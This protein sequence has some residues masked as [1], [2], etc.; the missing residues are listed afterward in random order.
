MEL[1]KRLGDMRKQ[2]DQLTEK[3]TQKRTR[4]NNEIEEEKRDDVSSKIKDMETRLRHL[5]QEYNKIINIQNMDNEKSR[6]RIINNY[7]TNKGDHK[8]EGDNSK[9]NPKVFIKILKNK[10]R[11]LT[12]KDDIKEMIR[13]SLDS[14]ALIWFTGKED[15]IEDFESFEE[16]FIKYFWGN[17]AQTKSRE[18]LY[19]GKYDTRKGYNMNEYAM[20]IYSNAKFL[21]P[22]IQEE[23]IIMF[24][25]RHYKPEITETIAIQNIKSIEQLSNY[26]QRIERNRNCNNTNI[27][28]DNSGHQLNNRGNINN[29]SYN[30]IINNQN[31]RRNNNF[32]NSYNQNDINWNNNYSRNNNNYNFRNH[33]NNNSNNYS[34][35]NNQFNN[36][37]NNINNNNNN[38]YQ[39]NNRNGYTNYRNGNNTN[40]QQNNY[41]EERREQNQSKE[42]RTRAVNNTR[43]MQQENRVITMEPEIVTEEVPDQNFVSSTGQM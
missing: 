30:E 40:Y 41:R 14:H 27:R 33:G 12:N 19:F 7:M 6:T 23:E 10:I 38:R 20:K 35:Y 11:N 24:L 37:D 16:H 4:V 26:L 2:I 8:F 32:H 42:E 15:E 21:D 34:R 17:N 5:Q 22:P 1:D 28:S 9:I 18:N 3:L 25:S 31:N 13:D 39:Y 29:N 36:N 43:R